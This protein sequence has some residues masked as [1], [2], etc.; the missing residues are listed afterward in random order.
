MRLEHVN[1]WKPEHSQAG[2]HFHWQTSPEVRVRLPVALHCQRVS[3][4][5]GPLSQWQ[6]PSATAGHGEP[7]ASSPFGER[8]RGCEC[9]GAEGCSELSSHDGAGP[10]WVLIWS[11]GSR[12]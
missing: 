6:C 2:P 8:L 3:T 1:C 7:E 10:R 11:S 12:L 4:V 5:R 9:G